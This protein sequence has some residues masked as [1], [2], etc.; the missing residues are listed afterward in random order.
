VVSIIFVQCVR[1]ETEFYR[2]FVQG[3]LLDNVFDKN[4]V[5]IQQCIWKAG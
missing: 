2:T 4:T 5:V 3:G 1:F